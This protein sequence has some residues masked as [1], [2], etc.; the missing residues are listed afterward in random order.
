MAG[1]SQRGR[2]EVRIGD[3]RA[4]YR[5]GRRRKVAR[6]AIEKVIIGIAQTV[7]ASSGKTGCAHRVLIET[8][9]I[10]MYKRRTSDASLSMPP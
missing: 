3:G 5:T 6:R 4:V 2:T 10:D 9:R 1:S 8:M 7:K